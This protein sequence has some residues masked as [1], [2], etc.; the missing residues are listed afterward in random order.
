MYF[1]KLVEML[2][3]KFD[4][5]AEKITMETNIIDDLGADSLD[6]VD[7]LMMLED[8]YSISIDDE[9]AQEL[10]T[11]GDVVKYLEENVQ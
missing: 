3:G 5:P 2:S 7:M 1:E 9:V 4:V 11:I 10:K 6:M 8:A